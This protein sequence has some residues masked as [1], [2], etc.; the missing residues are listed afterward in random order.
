MF[1]ATRIVLVDPNA[2]A[3]P[4][5]TRQLETVNEIDLL[6]TCPSYSAAIK[7]VAALMP[8]LVIVVTDHDIDEAT[9]LV[10]KV[11]ES[12]PAVAILP[13]GEDHDAGVIL[14]VV[15]AGA[16]EF[17]PLPSPTLELVE[18][19]RGLNP[20]R[21]VPT[22]TGPRGP[23]LIAVTG[24]A[25]G[26]GCTTLS[27]NLATNLAKISRRDTVI[28]D[29]DLL[30]GSLEECLAVVPENTIDGV[31]RNIDEMN[32]T[33]LKR[34]L[35]RHKNGLY[36]LPHP[37]TLEESAHLDLE[38]VQRVLSLLKD[39]FD[40]VVIDTSKGLQA[41]DFLAFEAA[42]IILVV[43]QL[44]V[45][46]TRNTVRLTNYLR[47]F[48]GYGEKIRLVANRTNSPQSEIST[49]KAEELLKAPLKYQVSNSTKLCR[50]AR[51]L[52]VPIDEVDGGAGSKL[53]QDLVAIAQD[54]HPFP[55]ETAKVKRKLFASFR[56][57]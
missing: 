29:F 52:G 39:S 28:A 32:P 24:A 27:V 31:V 16:R 50:P 2:R 18:T 12:L 44:N 7:R 33:L 55:P 34:W 51:T 37:V 46:C 26:V 15:R 1:D 6:E 36:M 14:R 49:K 19:V 35:P 9:E 25:G 11:A 17:L 23:K 30:L 5:L 42:D 40:S 21:I 4:A 54:L 57:A 41:T 56:S 47:S 20:R 45:N 43:L 10:A 53:H 13:A 8:D 3:N 38:G 48:E 22:L